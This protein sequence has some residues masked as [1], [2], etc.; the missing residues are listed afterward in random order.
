M[1]FSSPRRFGDVENQ[2]LVKLRGNYSSDRNLRNVS[3]NFRIGISTPSSGFG[4]KEDDLDFL[5]V[6]AGLSGECTYNRSLVITPLL[7]RTTYAYF[8]SEIA[9]LESPRIG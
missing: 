4:P 6:F 5:E 7:C 9:E 3:A 2:R 1:K 8:G